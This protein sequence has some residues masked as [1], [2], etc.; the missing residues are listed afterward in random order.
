MEASPRLDA[1]VAAA[2]RRHR[3]RVVGQTGLVVEDDAAGIPD[4]DADAVGA[5]HRR[6]E[7]LVRRRRAAQRARAPQLR[8]AGLQH[9]PLYAGA[10]E[11]QPRPLERDERIGPNDAVL[12]LHG[13]VELGLVGRW[14]E[15][16]AP[17]Y[18]PGV[19]IVDDDETRRG[20]RV[21]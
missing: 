17:G 15:P 3:P 18:E 4:L 19:R 7:E 21:L 20:T 5:L 9:E 16:A 6:Q 8:P 13:E 1:D 14:S 10:R 2:K 12:V 11:R